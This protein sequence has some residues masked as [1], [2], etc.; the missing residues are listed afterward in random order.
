ME[1]KISKKP[2]LKETSVSFLSEEWSKREE[3][4]PEEHRWYSVKIIIDDKYKT[5]KE[6]YDLQMQKERKA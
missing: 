1:E 2:Y 5:I 3:E 4:N 6:T